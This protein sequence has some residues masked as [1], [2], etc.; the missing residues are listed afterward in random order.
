MDLTK[1]WVY[2]RVFSP[3]RNLSSSFTIMQW[4]PPFRSVSSIY[5]PVIFFLWYMITFPKWRTLFHIYHVIFTSWESWLLHRSYLAW[6]PPILR[7]LQYF[8]SSG[9]LITFFTLTSSKGVLPHLSVSHPNFLL[10]CMVVYGFLLLLFF[11][12]T[13][14]TIWLMIFN[15]RFCTLRNFPFFGAQRLSFSENSRLRTYSHTFNGSIHVGNPVT[16]PLKDILTGTWASLLQFYGSYKT[17]VNHQ[18]IGK[19]VYRLSPHSCCFPDHM[20]LHPLAFE[21]PLT[22]LSPSSSI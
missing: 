5:I 16:I 19:K 9:T 11:L 2:I 8:F 3:S 14:V 1:S 18:W 12:I 22:S 20:S 21:T 10:F 13:S 17:C 4:Y 15:M 7:T 6:R